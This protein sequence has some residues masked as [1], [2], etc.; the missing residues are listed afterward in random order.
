[1]RTTQPGQSALLL[2]DAVVI[3]KKN[4]TD[5]AVI[6]AM[7]A[8]FYGAVR[9]SVDADAVFSVT[10]QS[11]KALENEFKK[12][13]FHVEL[14][15]GGPEDP[16]PALLALSDGFGNRVDLLTGIRGMDPTAFARAVETPFEGDRIRIIGL[17]DFIAMK[18]FAGSPKDLEDARQT[19]TVSGSSLDHSLLQQVTRRYGKNALKILGTL[20]KS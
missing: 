19:L 16:I 8:S 6:G 1:M 3:F 10:A 4:H 20:I 9:A 14:R 18:V 13:G 15:R 11:L 12:A 2:L 5:Y 7:A 17:E